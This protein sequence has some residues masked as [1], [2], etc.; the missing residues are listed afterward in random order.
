VH[1]RLILVCDA[2]YKVDRSAIG[3]IAIY[4]GKVLWTI[5]VPI[6]AQTSSEAEFIAIET[7]CVIAKL[8]G[9]NINIYTDSKVP[10]PNIDDNNINIIWVPRKRVKLAD[11]IARKITQHLN[12]Q[13]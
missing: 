7:A 5:A 1:D 10:R 4:K 2:S 13:E 3:I 6:Q 12:H 11:T 8:L 9:N